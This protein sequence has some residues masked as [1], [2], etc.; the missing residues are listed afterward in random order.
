MPWFVVYG[1]G[2]RN[3]DPGIDAALPS[4]WDTLVELGFKYFSQ[5]WPLMIGLMLFGLGALRGR[6]HPLATA[7]LDVSA[8]GLDRLHGRRDL[9]HQLL[10][11]LSLAAPHSA[12]HPGA[13]AAD[14]ARTRQFQEPGAHFSG[15]RDRDLRRWR[16]S[17]T[18][19]RKRPGIRSRTISRCYA[20]PD[21]LVLME[22]YRDDFT[23][24]YYID[25]LLSTRTP[26]ES[27]RMWR[28]DRASEYPDGLIERDRPAADRLARPLESRSV[29]VPVSGADRA[30]P[31]GEDVGRSLAAI[32]ST[33]TASTGCRTTPVA[34]FAN[35][36]TLRMDQIL[37]DDARVDLWWSADQPLGRDY[38][39]SVFRAR[40]RA[41]SWSRRTTAIPFENAR[42]TTVVAARRS[43]LRPAPAR[44]ERARA[45]AVHRRRADLHLAGSGQAADR[46]GDQW[47]A[48]GTLER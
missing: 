37:P 29:G 16:R 48:I 6:A 14:G 41:G 1:W 22:I 21:E 11:G 19:T 26:R 45:G 18:T 4:N 23:M 2:Q 40:R 42:P 36:M 9:H 12:A 47:L 8:G 33:C 44:P 35:G 17:T 25:Q 5:M 31:D 39:T 15:R 30:R 20:H 7:Q 43:R 38:T 27:L 28:E 34:Q 10:A 24:D 3:T 46:G 32:R 13:G